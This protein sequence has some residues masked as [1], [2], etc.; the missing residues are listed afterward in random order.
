MRSNPDSAPRT[1]HKWTTAAPPTGKKRSCGRHFSKKVGTGRRYNLCGSGIFARRL[2]MLESFPSRI[3]YRN[4]T[5]PAI[6]YTCYSFRYTCLFF[7]GFGVSLSLYLYLFENKERKK[8]RPRNYGKTPIHRLF[9]LPIFSST[10]YA[11]LP[12]LIRG[13][14]GGLKFMEIK[15]LSAV[16]GGI[17]AS[18]DKNAWGVL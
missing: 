3:G 5:S 11:P 7:A 10:G 1:P 14:P 16:R 13:F 12:P 17:P 2:L 15:G 6:N 18:P 4:H 9:V 8:E